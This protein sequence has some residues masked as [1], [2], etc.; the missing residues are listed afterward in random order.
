[1]R[2]WPTR[3]SPSHSKGVSVYIQRAGRKGLFVN[4]TF[5]DA[6]Q[7][8]ARDAERRSSSPR[9]T[10]PRPLRRSSCGTTGSRERSPSG[11]TST[12]HFGI[13]DYE[14][15]LR[16]IHRVTVRGDRPV[17]PSEVI[18]PPSTPFP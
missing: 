3:Q 18:G 8:R 15:E 14:G 16:A 6:R 12:M 7:G 1:M 11:T 2:A 13:Y 10:S 17:G 9:F 4:P 5:S